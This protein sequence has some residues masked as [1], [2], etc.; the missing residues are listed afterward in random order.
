M[1]CNAKIR[2]WAGR[3][4]LSQESEGCPALL[5]TPEWGVEQF[6][7]FY[8]RQYLAKENFEKIFKIYSRKLRFVFEVFSWKAA[9]KYF[10]V[11]CPRPPL[12]S[13]LPSSLSPFVATIVCTLC[14]QCSN[15][16]K[17]SRLHCIVW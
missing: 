14:V 2:R 8:L 15:C 1:H 6:S 7:V 5:E 9:F 3:F 12:P 16:L 11:L 13:K 4:V 10:Q 17:T